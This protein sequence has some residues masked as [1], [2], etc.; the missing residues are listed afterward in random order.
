MQLS[1]GIISE[2]CKVKGWFSYCA[3]PLGE[4]ILLDISPSF[5]PSATL[6]DVDEVKVE[7]Y[8]LSK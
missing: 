3:V 5:S 8:D 1:G 4:V 2:S 7:R 6:H